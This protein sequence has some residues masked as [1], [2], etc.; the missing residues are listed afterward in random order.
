M[1]AQRYLVVESDSLTKD[2]V[3]A[4]F[5]WLD[6]AVDLSL[7]AVVDT[8]GKSLHG[9]FE[10]P[11]PDALTELKIMLPALGCDSKMFGSSQP[12]RL[13]GGLRNGHIQKLIYSRNGDS[14]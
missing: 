4:I 5:R 10:F 12:C 6:Q 8:A 9:W 7:R 14:Q 3:G 11:T 1:T 2:Q 13:P